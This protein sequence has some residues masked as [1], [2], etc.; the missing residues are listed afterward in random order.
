MISVAELAELTQFALV[1]GGYYD[2]AQE[3][4]YGEAQ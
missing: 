1:Q 2:L 3:I 4:V